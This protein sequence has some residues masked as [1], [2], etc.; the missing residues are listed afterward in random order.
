MVRAATA[1]GLTG[2]GSTRIEFKPFD[3]ATKRAEAAYREADGLHRYTKGAPAVIAELCGVPES[4]WL[5]REQE[6]A[7]LGQ[8]VLGVATG[9]DGKLRF[10]GLVGLED[11]VR[12]DSR[13]VV[14]AIHDAG[15]RVV[16]VTGDNA[17]TARAVAEQVGIPPQVCPPG[18]PAWRPQRQHAGEQ[19]VRG[20]VSRRQIQ[21]G[22]R[23]P[24]A[25]RGGG[26]E[27]RRGE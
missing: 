14:K 3:P 15:V 11:A 12:D 25:G 19:R 22:P 24:A 27:R 16:M 2:N 13:A 23:L 9:E 20:C 7:A 18:R 17:L 26:H 21:A 5:P 4:V 8:R 1:R 6:L 10:A